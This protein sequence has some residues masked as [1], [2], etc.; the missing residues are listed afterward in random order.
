MSK[1]RPEPVP[2]KATQASAFQLSLD[3]GCLHLSDAWDAVLV[4][5]GG[6]LWL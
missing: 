4:P 5:Y 2:D 1:L 3:E 6:H